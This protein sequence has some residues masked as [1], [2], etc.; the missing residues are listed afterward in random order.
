MAVSELDRAAS[1]W[2]LALGC[3]RSIEAPFYTSRSGGLLPTPDTTLFI[4]GLW[5]EG[6]A[7]MLAVCVNLQSCNLCAPS[8]F[9]ARH[10]NWRDSYSCFSI[11]ITAL[12]IFILYFSLVELFFLI[13]PMCVCP[14]EVCS[15]G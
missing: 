5:T 11:S 15:Y 6:C 13:T 4:D 7:R 2:R 9:I 14:S 3:E 12:H 10:F 1:E 8:R